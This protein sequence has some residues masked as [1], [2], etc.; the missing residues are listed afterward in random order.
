MAASP[1]YL[2]LL[3]EFDFFDDD[4]DEL[5]E[6]ELPDEPLPDV[7]A[8]VP[9][10]LTAAGGVATADGLWVLNDSTSTREATVLTMARMTRLM[11]KACSQNSKLSE[12]I[13]RRGTLAARSARTTAPVMPAGPQTKTS[14]SRRSLMLRARAAVDSG[15][16]P[17]SRR[18]PAMMCS[19]APRDL[20]MASSSLRNTTSTSRP[21][22]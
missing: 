20:A 7:P 2:L 3:L 4:E 9:L 5:L 18:W 16:Y 13:W 1:V 21:L 14:W 12:W 6:D 11:T 19:R 15:S 8:L 17:S 22:R 10:E